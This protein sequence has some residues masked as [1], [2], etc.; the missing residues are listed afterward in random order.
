M[1]KFRRF[2]V[3]GGW[4][5]GVKEVSAMVGYLHILCLQAEEAYEE[6]ER[7][8]KEVNEKMHEELPNFYDR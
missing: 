7:L 3:H 1:S 6:A 4:G 8:Y 5:V 2:V